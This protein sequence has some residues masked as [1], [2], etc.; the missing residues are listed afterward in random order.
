MLTKLTIRNFKL[1]EEVTIELDN[2]VIFVGPNNSGKSTVLQALS[3]WELG[4][5]RWSEKRAD[6]TTF[7]SKRTGVAIN[8]LDLITLPLP[9]TKQLWR[10]LKV[11]KSKQGKTG[12]ENIRIEIIV[13]GVTSTKQWSIGLEFDYASPELI[14]CRPIIEEFS[15]VQPTDLNTIADALAIGYLSPMSGLSTN[16]VRLEQGAIDVRIG[17]GRT[18]EVLRNLCFQVFSTNLMAW[19]IIVERI[20]SLFGISLLDPHHVVERGEISMSYRHNGFELDL[21]ASGRGLQQTLLLLVYMYYKSA[22]VLLLDEPDAHL[23]ILRQRRIYHMLTEVS[24]LTNSQVIIASHSEVILDEAADT[25]LVIAFVGKPHTLNDQKSQLSKALKQI[26]W[27]DYY[28]A[29]TTGWI[30]YLEG[31]TD[32]AMLR[33][34]ASRLKHQAAMEALES[35]FVV[36]VGNVVKRVADHFYGILEALPDLR[37]ISLFD[38]LEQIRDDEPNLR[39]MTWTR[40]EIENYVCSRSTLE[41]FAVERFKQDLLVEPIFARPRAQKSLKIMQNVIDEVAH[42][43]EI[44]GKGTLWDNNTKASS[45]VL[46]PIFERY[47]KQLELPNRMEKKKF[48]EL[49]PFVPDQEIDHEIKEKLDAIVAVANGDV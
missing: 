10:A 17:E 11:R 36:T 6:R 34:F 16:E 12:T 25:D 5:K 15:S 13:E 1:F 2:P 18:A 47:F 27:R 42:S 38:Q 24:K 39:F 48:Y 35:P 8:R 26:D 32:L 45:E 7:S 4:L 46:E 21:A 20:E 44:L 23:E 22:S 3:L 33:A 29:K 31:F 37:G 30:L 14:H 19:Q 49:V 41:T 43:F 40:K 28:L 9:S